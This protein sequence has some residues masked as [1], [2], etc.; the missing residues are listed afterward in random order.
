MHIFIKKK[1]KKNEHVHAP[2]LRLLLGLADSQ[3]EHWFQL[4]L[5]QLNFVG[6]AH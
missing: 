1:E 5:I 4:K 3:T 6:L 2:R